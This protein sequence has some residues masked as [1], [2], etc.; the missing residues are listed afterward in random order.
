MLTR[1]NAA[2]FRLR[3]RSAVSPLIESLGEGRCRPSSKVSLIVRQ[4]TVSGS[5]WEIGLK[6][7]LTDASRDMESKAIEEE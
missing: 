3:S 2:T 5:F 4:E 6:K 1:S 7:L